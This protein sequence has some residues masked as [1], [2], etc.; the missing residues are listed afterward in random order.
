MSHFIDEDPVK[1]DSPT[2]APEPSPPRS[3]MQPPIKLQS[4]GATPSKSKPASPEKKDNAILSSAVSEPP[5]PI[6]ESPIPK[7][8]QDLRPNKPT[9]THPSKTGSK[10]K[11]AARDESDLPLIRISSKESQPAKAVPEKGSV[12][13]K[14]EGKT[15]KELASIRKEARDR[16][17]AIPSTRKPLS[18]KSTNNDVS[19]PRK[20]KEAVKDEITTAKADAKSKLNTKQKALQDRTKAKSKPASV[21]E[22]VLPQAS[23]NDAKPSVAELAAPVATPVLLLPPSPGPAP[24]SEEPRGDTPPPAHISSSGETS[25]ASR[26]NRTAV[27]YAE[28]NLRDKM[29]RPSKQ[30]FD[31]VSGEAYTRRTSQSQLKRDSDF[32]EDTSAM[33]VSRAQM[34][35]AEMGLGS[36]LA[37]KS[38]ASTTQGQLRTSATHDCA[39]TGAAEELVRISDNPREESSSFDS[40][41]YDFHDSSPQ[42]DKLSAPAPAKGRRQSKATRR[43]SEAVDGDDAYVPGERASTRRRSMMV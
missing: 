32:T 36:P 17:M 15:L 23:R 16:A 26:R 9:A 6:A 7:I 41:V 20:V 27:S 24:P 2:R 25:R 12:L 43:H 22:I 18:N 3:K 33:S 8:P 35:E 21:I 31:A 34:F 39:G 4:L 37:S 11:L 1:M 30:L 40:D 14:A 10:R 19:S 13:G 29:R 38:T 28:P 5:S 42:A